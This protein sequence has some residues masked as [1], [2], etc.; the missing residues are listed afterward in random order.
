M[1]MIEPIPPIPA[2][3]QQRQITVQDLHQT[4]Y[5]I[6]MEVKSLQ[7]SLQQIEA[8]RD[9]LGQA[10]KA[11]DQLPSCSLDTEIPIPVTS[12]IFYLG[13]LVDNQ[14][15]KVDIGT[16]IFVEKTIPQ[17]TLYYKDKLEMVVKQQDLVNA[18]I[19]DKQHMAGNLDAALADIAK[20]IKEMQSKGA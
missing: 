19:K 9:R 1:T 10:L 20:Q 8:V 3:K 13:K 2:Q 5:A 7:A 14:L 4:R 11:L 16:G 6:M 17:A 15:V 12:L 18:K